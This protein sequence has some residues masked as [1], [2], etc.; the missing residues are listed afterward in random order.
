MHFSAVQSRSWLRISFETAAAIS[1]VMPG[2]AAAS[3][4]AFWAGSSSYSSKP[5][6]LRWL[7]AAKAALSCSALG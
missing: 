4:A 2:A 3:F 1:G 6:T 5:P 7:I